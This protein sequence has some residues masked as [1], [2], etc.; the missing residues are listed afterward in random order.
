M[1]LGFYGRKR[2]AGREF[3]T[4]AFLSVIDNNDPRIWC[5]VDDAVKGVGDKVLPAVRPYGYDEDGVSPDTV[6]LIGIQP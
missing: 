5:E 6:A 3:M 2:E 4:Q 1:N